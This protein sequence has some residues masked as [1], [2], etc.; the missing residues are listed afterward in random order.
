MR[1]SSVP[2]HVGSIVELSIGTL[3]IHVTAHAALGSLD[4]DLIMSEFEIQVMGQWTMDNVYW[5]W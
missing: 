2:L 4:C 5:H 3:S 1:A